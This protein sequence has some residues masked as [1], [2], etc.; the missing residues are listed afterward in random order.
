MRLNCTG[1][2]LKVLKLRDL[3]VLLLT[4][5][6]QSGMASSGGPNSGRGRG[7]HTHPRCPKARHLGHPAVGNGVFRRP[8]FGARGWP[9][10]ASQ[11]PKGEAPGAPGGREWRLPAAQIRGAGVAIIRI[12]GAQRRGTWGTRHLT[13]RHPAPG[14]L[15]GVG[16][17]GRQRR[18]TWGTQICGWGPG[19]L[20]PLRM[21]YLPALSRL[22]RMR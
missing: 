22:A 12:P 2:W 19:D 5:R 10:Y 11:V 7:H 8:K 20:P 4:V 21:D 18:G 16:M 1:Y 3:F 13:A 9:S 14:F 15:F 17:P 6:L